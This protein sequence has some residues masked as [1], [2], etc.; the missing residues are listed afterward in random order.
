LKKRDQASIATDYNRQQEGEQFS[1]EDPP[2]LPMTPSFPKKPIFAGGGLAGGLALGFAVLY[3]L[4]ALD[5]SMHS[6]RDVEVCLKLP[7]L[8]LV[9]T[10]DPTRATRSN[11]KG[12]IKEL[13]F[14]GTRN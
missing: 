13:D 1:M 8:A 2:S 10:M 9:P 14:A 5:S 12:R 6:E 4:A 11:G 3:L 7:V